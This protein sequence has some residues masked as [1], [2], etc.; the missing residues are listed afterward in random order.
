MQP[1]DRLRA[2]AA[3]AMRAIE[4][5]SDFIFAVLTPT[6]AFV[7]RKSANIV[8]SVWIEDEGILV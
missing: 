1:V 5:I 8:G 3:D 6:D 4:R 7:F 2:P